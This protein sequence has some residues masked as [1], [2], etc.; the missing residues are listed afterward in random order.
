MTTRLI[1]PFLVTTSVESM[2]RAIVVPI[3]DAQEYSVYA[4]IWRDIANAMSHLEPEVVSHA[5]NQAA[6]RI[7]QGKTTCSSIFHES[8][9]DFL[10][11][12]VVFART[13]SRGEA[14]LGRFGSQTSLPIQ[15]AS[16]HKD[17]VTPNFRTPSSR[18]RYLIPNT[19][20]LKD[21]VEPTFRTPPNSFLSTVFRTWRQEYEMVL[22]LLGHCTQWPCV[23]ICHQNRRY[24]RINRLGIG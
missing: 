5:R 10:L 17:E 15:D 16:T 22:N 6:T 19:L 2:K 24:H 1:I 20:R 12:N 8:M 11:S 4:Q 7:T 9:D 3:L 13:T 23:P 21:E 14:V 18:S